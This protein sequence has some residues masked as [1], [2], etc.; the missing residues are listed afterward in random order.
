MTTP[1]LVDDAALRA[2][3]AWLERGGV[4][5]G[6]LEWVNVDRRAAHLAGEKLD[7]VRFHTVDLTGAKL[8]G[9]HFD[10]AEFL[11]VTCTHAA[12]QAVRLWDATITDCVFDAA[13]LTH[14]EFDRASLVRCS[15]S[16]ALLDVTSWDGATLTECDLRGVQFA[17]ADFTNARF[18]R[19]R[20]AGTHGVLGAD[21][22]L[23]VVEGDVS[24]LGDASHLVDA[25]GLLSY[26]SRPR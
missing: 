8:D 25:D 3:R 14:A 24:D 4:G 23:V 17:G 26:L 2:H 19:C 20:F 9:A 1:I 13:K 22:N 6:R 11:H 18:I 12:M 7:G 5:P 10:G 15:F 21:E 16:N